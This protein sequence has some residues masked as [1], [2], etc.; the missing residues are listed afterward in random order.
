[1]DRL[2]PRSAPLLLSGLTALLLGSCGRQPEPEP[3]PEPQVSTERAR[4]PGR[5]TTF[6]ELMGVS[7]EA[8]TPRVDPRIGVPELAFRPLHGGLPTTGTWRED[9]ILHDFTGDGRASIVASNREEDGLNAWVLDGDSWSLRVNG[10][11]RDLMYGGSAAA[12]FDGSGHQ[13]LLF[14]AHKSGLVMYLNDGAMNWREGPEIHSSVLMLDV[15]VGDLNGDGITDAAGIGQFNGGV[16]VYLGDGKGGL[17]HLPE[18]ETLDWIGF[19]LTIEL[20]DLDG[21]GLDD[22]VVASKVGAKALLT[23]KQADGTLAWVDRSEGLPAPREGNTMRSVVTADILGDGRLEIV[24][25]RI[26]LQTPDANHFGVFQWDEAAGRWNQID[27]GVPRETPYTEALAGD[28][29]RDG[30]LDVLVASS[31][32]LVAIYLGDGTGSFNLAGRLPGVT[33][34]RHRAALGDITGN[35]WVDVLL[36]HGASKQ[37]RGGGGLH[38]FLNGPEVWADLRASSE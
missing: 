14:A 35:G 30:H 13:D 1:M 37:D 22:I 25:C 34:A 4:T 28:F 10:F 2:P 29:D 6:E 26:G 19:G 32:G 21:D 36:L 3:E 16:Q 8:E 31:S 27:R 38:A 12:D 15:A 33:G 9:P 18:S 20:A 11:R 24:A 23:R 17:R 5:P 7:L